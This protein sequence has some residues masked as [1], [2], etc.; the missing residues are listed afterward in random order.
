MGLAQRME[1]AAPGR[2]EPGRAGASRS[3]SPQQAARPLLARCRLGGGAEPWSIAAPRRAAGRA[4]TMARQGQPGPCRAVS[5]RAVPCCG[6][7]GRGGVCP[8]GAAARSRGEA[9]GAGAGPPGGRARVCPGA[10]CW[11]RRSAGGCA[12]N[13][14][15]ACAQT[16]NCC[17]AR[18]WGRG[19]PPRPRL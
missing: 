1:G 12:R 4:H 15:A 9:G 11:G 5:S 18:T 2:A 19:G 8:P 17:I 7:G 13:G 14:A 16:C 6:R 10:R 3:F